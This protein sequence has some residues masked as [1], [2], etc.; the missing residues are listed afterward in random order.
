MCLE[1]VNCFDKVLNAEEQEIYIYIYIGWVKGFS[2][3]VYARAEV[4]GW[5]KFLK[6]DDDFV[7]ASGREL[8]IILNVILSLSLIPHTPIISHII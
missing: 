3:C 1:C 7:C 5:R 8:G 2:V 6:D 4:G